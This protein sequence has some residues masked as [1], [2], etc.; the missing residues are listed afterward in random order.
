MDWYIHSNDLF[1][2]FIFDEHKGGEIF[3]LCNFENKGEQDKELLL[4]SFHH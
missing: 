3:V 1:A 4:S 2:C